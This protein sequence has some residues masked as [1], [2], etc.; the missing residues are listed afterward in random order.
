MAMIAG[1]GRQI[2]LGALQD[3]DDAEQQ[4]ADMSGRIKVMPP[5][6]RNRRV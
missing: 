3:L 6:T 2:H 1:R 4:H 5:P